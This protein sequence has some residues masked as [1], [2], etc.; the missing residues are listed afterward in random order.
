[1]YE[2]FN[3]MIRAKYNL[4]DDM[5]SKMSHEE[6]NKH[7][8]AMLDNQTI[9][10]FPKEGLQQIDGMPNLG[11]ILTDL[12]SVMTKKSKQVK[13]VTKV[14]LKPKTDTGIKKKDNQDDDDD[15]KTNA[16]AT[17]D[18]KNFK[19]NTDLYKRMT[20]YQITMMQE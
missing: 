20:E 10:I 14:Q 16:G 3:Q 11:I 4:S 9:L 13:N 15:K 5:Y 17:F 7:L 2:E 8:K 18:P 6:R 19:G 12:R 1:M